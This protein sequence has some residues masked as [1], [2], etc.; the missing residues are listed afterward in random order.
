[1]KI[2]NFVRSRGFSFFGKQ[3]FTLI[4]LLVVIAIIAILAAL[5]LPALTNAKVEALRVKCQDNNK[6]LGI[7]MH[8]Y[9]SDNSDFMPFPNYMNEVVNGPGW[10]Y[11]PIAGGG[12]WGG[13]PADPTVL[14]FSLNPQSAWTTGLLWPYIKN[15]GIYRCPTD[16]PTLPQFALRNNKLST[17]VFSD[18]VCG[19]GVLVGQNPNTLKLSRFRPTGYVMWEPDD[20]PPMGP[21]AYDDGCNSPDPGDSGGVGRRHLKAILLSFDAHVDIIGF[22]QYSNL[23]TILPGPLWCNPLTPLG[24]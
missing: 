19:R 5:L 6:Q 2:K 3:A 12:I 1:M 15:P 7:S 16:D 18:V 8:L 21:G 13:H 10:L 14:P 22:M 17:Y 23:V 20:L 24:N 11:M 9:A 4:E